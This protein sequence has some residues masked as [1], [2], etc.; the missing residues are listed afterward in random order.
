MAQVVIFG[1]AG[2]A[3]SR[4]VR[5]AASRGHDV[6]AVARQ[7]STLSGLPGGVRSAAGDATSAASVTAL[8]PGADAL[9]T[10]VGGSDKSVYRRA[11]QTVVEVLIALAE[12]AP[13]VIDMGGGGSLLKDDGSR[14][15]D[16]P[17]L[18]PDLVIEMKA[19]A[20]ALA[21]YRGSTGVRWTYVSPPRGNFVPGRRTGHYRT[22]LEHPVAAA[23]G[24]FEDSVNV[25]NDDRCQEVESGASLPRKAYRDETAH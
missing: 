17:G 25:F 12:R 13:R 7:L 16:A 14:F 6:V 15:A 10:A 21:V 4:I 2:K 18:P 19:Q 11:A 23:D 9:V 24:T 20:E 3:G 22:G 1:A 5:E 8:A